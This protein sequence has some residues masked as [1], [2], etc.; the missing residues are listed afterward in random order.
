M[1]IKNHKQVSHAEFKTKI[2]YYEQTKEDAGLRLDYQF[3]L[4]VVIHCTGNAIE[5]NCCWL[6]NAALV[7]AEKES[8][9]LAFTTAYRMMQYL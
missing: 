3:L 9:S 2:S 7:A 1:L 4:N 6:L 8:P 5:K